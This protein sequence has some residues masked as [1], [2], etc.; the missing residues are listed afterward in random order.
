MLVRYLH[1]ALGGPLL[2]SRAYPGPKTSQWLVWMEDRQGDVG[3]LVCDLE[4]NCR[5]KTGLFFGGTV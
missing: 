1:V 5:L 3:W 4:A 2:C